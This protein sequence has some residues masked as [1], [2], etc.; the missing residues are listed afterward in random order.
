AAIGTDG[1]AGHDA[2]ATLGRVAAELLRCLDAA[3]R[4]AQEAIDDD[5]RNAV[6]AGEIDEP[7]IVAE[8][9]GRRL[10][11]GIEDADLLMADLRQFPVRRMVPGPEGTIGEA[12]RHAPLA[13]R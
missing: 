10:A 13:G 2:H 1:D 4:I 7:R 8:E 6:A 3:M 11:I 9:A 5:G 12:G